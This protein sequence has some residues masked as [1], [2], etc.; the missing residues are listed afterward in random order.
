VASLA[1]CAGAS[2]LLLWGSVALARH[3]WPA[4]FDF[5]QTD[6]GAWIVPALAMATFGWLLGPDRRWWPWILAPIAVLL[7]GATMIVLMGTVEHVWNLSGFGA[8]MPYFGI[9]LIC[10]CGRPLAVRLSRRRAA[11]GVVPDAEPSTLNAPRVRRLRPSVLATAAA[12]AMLL[13][14]ATAF[15]LDPGPAHYAEAVP[16]YLGARTYVQD[17]RARSDLWRGMVAVSRYRDRYGSLT[18]FDATAARS[19]APRVAWTDGVPTSPSQIGLSYLHARQGP[20]LVVMSGTGTAFCARDQ[21]G[22]ITYGSGGGGDD[23]STG[24]QTA[25]ADA[26]AQAVAACG[27]TP[28]TASALRPFPIAHLCDGV[29]DEALII[30]RAVQSMLRT[31]L[32]LPDLPPASPSM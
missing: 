19:V 14:S 17:L 2:A 28:F 31:T 26:I 10:S 25:P 27:S 7:T 32:R 5:T 18:G 1:I 20:T 11:D 9:G 3:L 8:A 12:A 4:E 21:A 23:A 6:A 16:T 22:R 29:D 15:L 13:V 30:C 24:I